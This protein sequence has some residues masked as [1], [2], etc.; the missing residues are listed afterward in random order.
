MNV[1]NTVIKI[2]PTSLHQYVKRIEDSPLG[3][4]LAKGAFWS[5]TGTSISRGLA[6]LASILVA[7]MLGK[8]GFGE[9]G[10]IQNT[11][12]MFGVFSGFGMG[13][14]ATK[15]VAEFKLKAPDKAGR[16]M[17][18]SGI[19]AVIS[20]GIMAIALIIFA[21]WLS[22]HTL[23]APHL[24]RLLQVSAGLL[25]LTALNGAQTG[26]LAGFEA[27][28]I[29]AYVNLIGGITAFPL[30][31][32]GAYLYGLQGTIC[33]LVAS[34][35]I[36]WL[37]NH[38]A[39]RT[40]ARKARVP[41]SFN[42]CFQEWQVL[43]SFSLPAV[44]AG[45]MTGPV[46]WACS[47]MVVNQ[48]NGYA[49][50]GVYNA[51]NQW[52]MAISFIP[53]TL[54]AII[55]PILSSLYGTDNK[56]YNKVLWLNIILNTTV[57]LIVALPIAGLSSFIME[58]YGSGFQEGR[59]VLILLSAVSVITTT[60]SVIGQSISSMGKMWNGFCL[61]AIWAV[62]LVGSSWFLTKAG[63]IGLALAIFIAYSVHLTTVSFYT[64]TLLQK[65]TF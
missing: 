19:V 49:D 65:Q 43:W 58:G 18:L 28:K 36:N 39:L 62:T 11:V 21:P 10:I 4:R 47:A 53:S 54:G 3:Y 51:A 15:Y 25:F 50:M 42:G 63:A 1:K 55:L 38:I 6:L 17:A 23:A 32:G 33:G 34:A 8:T 41:F 64:W 22:A 9:L 26:A 30:M 48:P 14:T 31:V 24:S 40:E 5:L 44:L 45:V 61:N 16:I 2:L 46:T 35:G 59:R 12:G 29:I 13:L 56:R 20:G 57:A 7:R 52:Q 60:L 27:F 37:L